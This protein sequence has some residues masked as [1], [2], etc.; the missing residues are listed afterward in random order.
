MQTTSTHLTRASICTLCFLTSTLGVPAASALDLGR[1][2][3]TTAS[4]PVTKEQRALPSFSSVRLDS[5]ARVVIRQAEHSS[6]SI[7]AEANIAPLIES[8]VENGTLVIRDLKHFKSDTAEIVIGVRQL[9]SIETAG[10]VAVAAEALVLPALSVSMTGASA[11]S[12]KNVTIA[13]LHAALGGK[14][15]LALGGTAKELS[16]ELGGAAV[17]QAANLEAKAV[18]I[19]GGGSSQ[20]IVRATESLNVSL[21]GSAGVG[22]YGD[23]T[24]RLAT[25]GSATVTRMGS[26]PPR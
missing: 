16:A 25:S 11:M 23:V 15:A 26:S 21:G 3:A 17:L 13:R 18:S 10:T 19:S 6:V 1:V 7:E 24:P 22:F 4:G 2:W 14:S 12:L 5:D 8:V 9:G 20:T